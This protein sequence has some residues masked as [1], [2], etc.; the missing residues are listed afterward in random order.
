M[1][2]G[3]FQLWFAVRYLHVAS[4]TLLVGGASTILLWSAVRTAADVPAA[5]PIAVVY[6]W[7]FWSVAGLTAATGVSN[8]GLKGE[9]LLGPD[10][11]WGTALTVKLSTAILLLCLSVVRTHVVVRC[12]AAPDLSPRR[13]RVVLG[14]L[15]GLSVMTLLGAVWLGLGLA[16]GR[17]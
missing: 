12:A 1:P 10:T 11:G 17:Y 7:M 8:L 2:G 15:Y 9:G 16:H 3:F 4:A 14:T 5:L 6:E 13:T